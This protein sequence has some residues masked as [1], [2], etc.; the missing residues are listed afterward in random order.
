MSRIPIPTVE[1]APAASRALL[2]ATDKRL[3]MVPNLYRIVATSP[4]ALEALVSFHRALDKGDLDPLTRER[5]S[6]AVAEVIGCDYCL[7][8]QTYRVRSAEMLDDAEITAN[9]SGASNDIKADV[10]VRFAAKLARTRG[11]VTDLDVLT[12]REAG[13]SDGEIV[14]I[15]AHV[16]VSL[17][18]GIA[19]TA[20]QTDIDFPHI[21]A[22]NHAQAVTEVRR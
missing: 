14:E 19:N 17:F 16:A 12:A 22:R 3:G 13:Y 10:A 1:G 4:A 8:A 20:L 18:T 9:R 15:I 2:A 21:G 11:A 6:L 7:S 5:I